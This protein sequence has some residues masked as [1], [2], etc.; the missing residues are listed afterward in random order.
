MVS[1]WRTNLRRFRPMTVLV[2]A[3]VLAARLRLGNHS[4]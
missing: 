2:V 4:E 1:T 3:G